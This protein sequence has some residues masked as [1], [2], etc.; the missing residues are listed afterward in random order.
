M[1]KTLNFLLCIYN[2]ISTSLCLTSVFALLFHSFLIEMSVVCPR[3]FLPGQCG[4]GGQED[5]A[6]FRGLVLGR[7]HLPSRHTLYLEVGA[8]PQCTQLNKDEDGT[9]ALS[10]QRMESEA[11]KVGFHFLLTE[12]KALWYAFFFSLPSCW[13]LPTRCLSI[14]TDVMCNLKT[15]PNLRIYVLHGAQTIGQSPLTLYPVPWSSLLACWL[16][17]PRIPRF[18]GY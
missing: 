10:L 15:Y 12:A 16:I 9:Q 1:M 7:G 4:W 13:H 11:S 3:N 14:F 2:V 8:Q 6:L 17:L 5:S 18:H